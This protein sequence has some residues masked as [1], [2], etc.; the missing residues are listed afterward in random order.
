MPS[1]FRLSQ[2]PLAFTAMS[3][4]WL[5]LTSAHCNWDSCPPDGAGDPAA[6]QLRVCWRRVFPAHYCRAHDTVSGSPST[7]YLIRSSIRT[8]RRST[9]NRTMI[10]CCF[11][12]TLYLFSKDQ[13][14]A[15]MDRTHTRGNGYLSNQERP[16]GY[17]YAYDVWSGALERMEFNTHEMPADAHGCIHA[18]QNPYPWVFS[19]SNTRGEL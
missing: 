2:P 5:H 8:R 17:G 11:Y 12:D 1:L 16:H 19:V 18:C 15:C 14:W 4:T 10:Q 9:G 13:R 6:P 3:N 7:T